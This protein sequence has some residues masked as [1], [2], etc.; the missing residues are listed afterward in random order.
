M[1]RD[2]RLPALHRGGFGL[3]GPALPSP[4]STSAGA[5]AGGSV[6]ASS[7]RPGLSAWRAGALPP[8]ATVA[9]RYRRTPHLAPPSGS[10]P[11]TPL[12]ERGCKSSTT[13][14]YRSQELNAYCI[15]NEGPVWAGCRTRLCRVAFIRVNAADISATHHI[16]CRCNSSASA[17]SLGKKW[18]CIALRGM[19]SL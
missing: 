3:P 9:S 6:I 13:N 2:A 11:E 12:D 16:N 19:R 15:R 17:C 10:P 18:L 7:S 5:S 8:G 14:A 4:S 1:T